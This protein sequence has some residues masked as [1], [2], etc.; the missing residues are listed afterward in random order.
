MSQRFQNKV[1]LITGASSGIGKATALRAAREGAQVILCA[2]HED[3]LGE[4]ARQ[5]ETEG[6]RACVKTLDVTDQNRFNRVVEECLTEFGKI[7]VLVNNA[8]MMAPGML[9]TTSAADWRH[10]FT[11]T[12]DGAFYGIQ[13][14]LPAMKAQ[15]QGAIINVSSVCA[16]L[17]TPGVAGYSAAK[18]ALEALSRNTAIECA[19]FNVRSNVVSPGVVMTPPT[20]QAIPDE[21]G[22]KFTASTVPLKRI[23]A[24]EEIAAAILFLASDDAS[25]ITAALLPVDGGRAAELYTGAADYS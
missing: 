17:A 6:G 8:M 3:T 1:L 10:N 9:D 5:I 23:A 21:A 22:Q 24:P 2:R 7:D 19:P 4:V 11:A 14:V 13:A 20:V 12:V 15:K 18:A 16:T 25:Y